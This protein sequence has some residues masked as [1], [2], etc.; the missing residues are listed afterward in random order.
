[1]KDHY[2]PLLLKQAVINK[3][4]AFL[5]AFETTLG[6]YFLVQ[7]E[8]KTLE[9]IDDYIGRDDMKAS[10]VFDNTLFDIIKGKA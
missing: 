10:R 7:H 5:W 1:M 2:E 3:Q 8:L 9:L 6:D 4:H